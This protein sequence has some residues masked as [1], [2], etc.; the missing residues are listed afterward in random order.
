MKDY[1]RIS[2]LDLAHDQCNLEQCGIWFLCYYSHNFADIINMFREVRGAAINGKSKLS[3]I[4]WI[5]PKR[6]QNEYIVELSLNCNLLYLQNRVLQIFSH[7]ADDKW[8][9]FARK[10]FGLWNTNNVGRISMDGNNLAIWRMENSYE[11]DEI[12]SFH[13]IIMKAA[14]GSK[15]S[16]TGRPEFFCGGTVISKDFVMT[17]AHCT[18]YDNQMVVRLGT[19]SWKLFT[20][21]WQ[22]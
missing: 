19:V 6:F 21:M 4:V 18:E 1:N 13:F 10:A 3:S 7:D 16:A 14:V 9:Q 11:Y 15:S 8:N 2:P 22:R 20:S 12:F 5:W 17:A